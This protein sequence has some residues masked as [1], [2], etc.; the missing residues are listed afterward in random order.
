MIPIQGCVW[1]F[2]KSVTLDWKEAA[3]P[4]SVE[5]GNRYL[6]KQVGV[7]STRLNVVTHSLNVEPLLTPNFK[8]WWRDKCF[9]YTFALHSQCY[10]YQILYFSWKIYMFRVITFKEFRITDSGS[11]SFELRIEY[12]VQILGNQSLLLNISMSMR[13]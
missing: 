12:T 7:G 3:V 10:E 4:N 2:G 6:G 11:R 1:L 9:A 8:R 13:A 5:N